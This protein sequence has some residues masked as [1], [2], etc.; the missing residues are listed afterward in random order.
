MKYALYLSTLLICTSINAQ[1]NVPV[2]AIEAKSIFSSK[3]T[4]EAF[5]EKKGYKGEQFFNIDWMESEILL[6]TGEEIYGEKLKYNGLL[7]EL[8]W[9]NTTSYRQF[10]VDKSFISDFWLKN[11]TGNSN[12]FKRINVN[13]QKDV[14]SSDIFAE[15][16]VEGKVSLFIQRRI[17]VVDEETIF[18]N[19]TLYLLESLGTKPLYYIKTPSNHYL[20]LNRIR[21]NSFLNLFPEQKKDIAKI[22]KENHLNLK[23]ENDLIKLIEMLDKEVFK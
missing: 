4:G 1:T 15:V 2:K 3:L 21:K 16:G 20:L 5:I 9:V 11:G 23:T 7:D 6:S 19:G 17:K 10:K 12:H 22:M 18:Q 13:E 8:I 14:H